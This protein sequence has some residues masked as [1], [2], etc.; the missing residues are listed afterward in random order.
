MSPSQLPSPPTPESLSKSDLLTRLALLDLANQN[1]AYPL[2]LLKT[3]NPRFMKVKPL[4]QDGCICP[5]SYLYVDVTTGSVY[6][7][8]AYEPFL[9][10]VAL[11]IIADNIVTADF[12]T[13]IG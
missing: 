4:P 1:A 2:R 11:D 3:K 12:I 7:V 6:A 13:W 10:E 9:T 5:E 8:K